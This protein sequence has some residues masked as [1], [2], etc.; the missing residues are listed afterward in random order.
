MSD[1]T[2]SQPGVS[3]AESGPKGCCGMGIETKSRHKNPRELSGLWL[4]KYQTVKRGCKND[5]GT[6]SLE[7]WQC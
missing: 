6:K 5:E 4:Y 3:Y 2:I 1:L 7:A